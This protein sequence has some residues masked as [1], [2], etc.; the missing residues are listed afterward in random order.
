MNSEPKVD[1]QVDSAGPAKVRYQRAAALRAAGVLCR[2]LAV[3]SGATC[4][5]ICAGSL[6]RRKLEVGDVELLYIPAWR[7]V[8]TGLFSEDVLRHNLTELAITELLDDGVIRKRKNSLG[9]E[10]WG[11]KNKLAVHVATGIPVDFFM[12]P[13][14]DDW[15]RTL[16]IRTGPRDFNLRLIQSAAARG[17]NVHAYGTGLTR[18]GTGETI[19]CHSEREF[20]ELCGLEY[21]EPW[22]RR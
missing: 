10:T 18:S 8:K 9:G 6:R 3:E 16:V 4:R 20:I 12:E 13:S 22:E 15:W 11:S 7:E 19:P 5:L 1:Y 2:A 21:L 17:I 14:T